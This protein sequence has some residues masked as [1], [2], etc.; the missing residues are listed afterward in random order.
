LSSK[1]TGERRLSTVR[2]CTRDRVLSKFC[3]TSHRNVSRGV[4]WSVP[5]RAWSALRSLVREHW[6][7]T[8]SVRRRVRVSVSTDLHALRV[9]PDA[10]LRFQIVTST[11]RAVPLFPAALLHQF[12]SIQGKASKKAMQYICQFKQ[13]SSIIALMSNWSSD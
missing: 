11:R 3:T 13:F 6:H 7:C 5:G 12:N 1:T 10:F 2:H 9:F 8:D 4:G